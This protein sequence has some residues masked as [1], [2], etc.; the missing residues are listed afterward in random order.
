MVLSD[1]CGS[2]LF[3][4]VLDE[5]TSVVCIAQRA[6]ELQKEL[7]SLKQALSTEG[8]DLEE[9]VVCSSELTESLVLFAA[10]SVP[11]P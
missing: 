2:P 5:G 4:K 7:L 1:T 11:Q 8:Q 9:L 10:A 6:K 3:L